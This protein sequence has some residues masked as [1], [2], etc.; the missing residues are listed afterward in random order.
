MKQI[1]KNFNNLSKKTIF[2]LENK[3]NNKFQVS[4]FNKCVIAI[5]S[6]LFIYIFYSLIPLLYDKNW[7]QNK[8]ISKLSDEFNI[9]LINSPDISYRVLP[10]P[11][12]LIKNSK[13]SLAKIEIIKIFINQN[14]CGCRL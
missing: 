10:K 13:I 12:F 2:K 5:I 8:I 9:S 14:N 3:T 4:T 6:I 7:L 1:V 11:H